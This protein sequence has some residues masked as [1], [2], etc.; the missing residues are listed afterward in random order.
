MKQYQD[1]QFGMSSICKCL[2]NQD[3]YEK[4]T[5]SSTNNIHKCL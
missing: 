5:I 4:D 2:K 3:Q 1:E